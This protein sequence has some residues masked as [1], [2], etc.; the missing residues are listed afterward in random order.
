MDVG[1]RPI[2]GVVDWNNASRLIELI[3]RQLCFFMLFQKLAL[4]QVSSVVV[5][6]SQTATSCRP[7]TVIFRFSGAQNL[8]HFSGQ[9]STASTNKYKKPTHKWRVQNLLLY[10]Y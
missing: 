1:D 8:G 2:V 7:L 9:F 3:C 4:V 5:T 6:L 10:A